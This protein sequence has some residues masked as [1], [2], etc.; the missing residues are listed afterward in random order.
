MTN[1]SFHLG[2][3]SHSLFGRDV[4]HI[5]FPPLLKVGMVTPL[6]NTI[7][8]YETKITTKEKMVKVFIL[9]ITKNTSNPFQFTSSNRFS[10]S[11]DFLLHGHPSDDGLSW[12]IMFM[13]NKAIPRDSIFPFQKLL[14]NTSA[15][16]TL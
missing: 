12:N 7:P 4:F 1:M 6:K 5:I 13:P 10:Y 2:C 16:E 9:L 8:H 15:S 3:L 14:P 11:D